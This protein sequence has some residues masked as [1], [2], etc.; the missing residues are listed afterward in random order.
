MVVLSQEES[1]G[2]CERWRARANIHDGIKDLPP[3]TADKFRYT[4]HQPE[5]AFL[6]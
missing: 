3:D 5:S 2:R 1:F 4:P 6:G